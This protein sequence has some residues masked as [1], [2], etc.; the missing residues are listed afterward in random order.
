MLCYSHVRPHALARRVVDHRLLTAACIHD[1]LH[2]SG[3]FSVFSVQQTDSQAYVGLPCATEFALCLTCLIDWVY[4]LGV[5]PNIDAPVDVSSTTRPTRC[6]QALQ[7][8]WL[9]KKAR[10]FSSHS[11]GTSAAPSALQTSK[12]SKHS[13]IAANH[14]RVVASG[15]DVGA[16]GRDGSSHIKETNLLAADKAIQQAAGD[17]RWRTLICLLRKVRCRGQQLLPCSAWTIKQEGSGMTVGS[18]QTS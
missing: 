15:S 7:H 11:A 9:C 6:V 16:S 1:I 4:F 3:H 8:S 14:A 12:V 2:I 13:S 17:E 10:Q 18:Q 5:V